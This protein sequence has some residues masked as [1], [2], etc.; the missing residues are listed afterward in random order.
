MAKSYRYFVTCPS[1]FEYQLGRELEK[2]VSVKPL[3]KQGGA[4]FQGTFRDGQKVCLW[5]R[6]AGKVLLALED[7]YAPDE[8]EIYSRA[9]VIKWP[10]FF[11]PEKTIAVDTTSLSRKFNNASYLSLL[12]K[13]GISDH[14]RAVYDKRPDVDRENPDIRINLFTARDRC[15]ISLDISGGSLHQRGYRQKGGQAPLKENLAA[16]LLERAGW[17]K[18]SSESAGF[19]DPMCGSGTF[20]IEAAMIAT[21]TAPGFLRK[22]YSF[23]HLKQF[24][25]DEWEK[26]LAEA[27]EKRKP[28]NIK[29]GQIQGF[30]IDSDAVKTAL[31]N[32]KAAGFSGLIDVKRKDIKELQKPSI[33]TAKPGLI[34]VNLPY[35]MRLGEDE[36]L[37]GLYNLAGEKFRTLFDGWKVLAL[38][39]SQE[40]SREL[41]M[42]PLQ[43]NTVYNGP[44]KCVSGIF[45]VS[46]RYREQTDNTVIPENDFPSSV[47]DSTDSSGSSDKHQEDGTESRIAS[48]SG[49]KEK[50]VYYSEM[51]ANRLKKN[52][53]SLRKWKEKEG[54]S[55]YRIYD[56]DMPEYSAAIDIYGDNHLHI[57][58]YA[59]PPEIP[60]SKS[61]KRFQDIVYT[62]EKVTGIPRKEISL[63][64]RKR[65][66]EGEKYKR[67]S[68][69]GKFDTINEGGLSFCVNFHDYLDTGIF[70]DHRIIR[71][72]IRE[73][74][75]E[76]K[77]LNLFSYTGTA[78]VYA[79]KGGASLTVSV[80]ANAAYCEWTERNFKANN[81]SL[82]ANKIIKSDFMEFLESDRG[83]YDIIFIDP[84]TF[85]NS[86]SRRDIFVI[87]DNHTELIKKASEKLLQ[88]G[89]IIFSSNF[90]KFK[91]DDSIVENFSVDDITEKTVS[92]DFSRR[93][94][95]RKCWVIS[96]KAA[97]KT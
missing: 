56:A 51:L 42:K 4:E 48:A 47:P 69:S 38:S 62:A 45:A 52:I 97:G 70:L 68:S 81:L 84:P 72:M 20:L 94:F 19:I 14:F 89:I 25:K 34:A 85:S 50:S 11:S 49:T 36:E 21:D 91:L 28:G 46:S 3:Q 77:F 64:Q 40:L 87:Q 92:P 26:L 15:T 7:F 32:I 74:S 80:D 61:E 53:K 44:I 18:M 12:V 31:L 67:I 71:G 79:A 63:R 73:I 90:K 27:A 10:D 54:I 5:S 78:S 1:G 8:N 13:D 23:K 30:D 41:G 37:S 35:G 55:C 33:S 75:S 58:E 65:Q 43:V 76:R 88:N 6:T 2:I 17:D 39:G 60:E 9:K 86:K 82:S 59:P 95:A 93:G 22:E 24:K 66:K 29:P 16:A 96:N 57:Q 83:K